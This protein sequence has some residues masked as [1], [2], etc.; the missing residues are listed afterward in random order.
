MPPG[1]YIIAQARDRGFTIDKI[2]FN[3]EVKLCKRLRHSFVPAVFAG[4]VMRSPKCDLTYS[5][6]SNTLG[7]I[8]TFA[9]DR[10]FNEDN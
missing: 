2:W 7:F 1:R 5:N 9:H 6:W 10:K 3:S 4:E 8:G